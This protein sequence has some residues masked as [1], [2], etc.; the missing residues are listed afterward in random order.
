[1]HIM[2]SRNIFYWYWIIHHCMPPLLCWNVQRNGGLNVH[3]YPT[4]KLLVR[5]R[6]CVIL[7]VQQRKLYVSVG[8]LGSMFAL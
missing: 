2:C 6:T 7:S 1:M 3:T 5:Y 8:I 4:W